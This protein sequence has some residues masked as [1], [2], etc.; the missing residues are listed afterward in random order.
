[1]ELIMKD[2]LKKIW[3]KD[4][5]KWFGQVAIHI[6]VNGNKIMEMDLENIS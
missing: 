2:N 3:Q 6:L 1:M 4:L 5:E